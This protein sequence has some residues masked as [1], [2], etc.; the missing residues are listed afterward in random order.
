MD[1][2]TLRA[3][4]FFISGVVGL[5]AMFA[6]RDVPAFLW[7]LLTAALSL[8]SLQNNL[9]RFGPLHLGC[10][11]SWCNDLDLLWLAH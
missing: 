6:A 9:L 8:A 7:T 2:A 5:I 3:A 1:M 10:L 4:C 11:R